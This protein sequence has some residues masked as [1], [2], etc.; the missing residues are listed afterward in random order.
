MIRRLSIL[1][2]AA[3]LA[4]S[5]AP[6]LAGTSNTEFNAG[7]S[8][9]S[10]PLGPRS[11]MDVP[12]DPSHV[13]NHTEGRVSLVGEMTEDLHAVVVMIGANDYGLKQAVANT[14]EGTVSII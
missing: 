2:A 4:A 10:A 12:H 8:S 5:A 1:A 9:V 6:A 14:T 3:A 7:A 11:Q 13:A